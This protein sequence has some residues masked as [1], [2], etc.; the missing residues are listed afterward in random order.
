MGLSKHQGA[1]QT[2]K[3]V[4]HRPPR[5]HDRTPRRRLPYRQSGHVL[6]L[7]GVANSLRSFGKTAHNSLDRSCNSLAPKIARFLPGSLLDGTV[8]DLGPLSC[9][10]ARRGAWRGQSTSTL[11]GEWLRG[12]GP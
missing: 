8:R 2:M 9:D 10:T 12:P 1:T 6:A 7:P 3:V 11:P 4:S 5:E